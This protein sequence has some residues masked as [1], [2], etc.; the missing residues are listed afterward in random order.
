MQIV[1]GCRRLCTCF[2]KTKL[3]LIHKTDIRKL[4]V[5]YIHVSEYLGKKLLE[6]FDVKLNRCTLWKHFQYLE[7]LSGSKKLGGTC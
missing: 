1:R 6:V 4:A 3:V 5:Q 7:T 2:G